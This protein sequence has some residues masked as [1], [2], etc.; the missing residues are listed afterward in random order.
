M[1]VP[2]PMKGDATTFVNIGGVD[3]LANLP[4]LTEAS[5]LAEINA[6]FMAHNI[7]TYV[8]DILI[9]M[10]P[11][12]RY[13]IYTKEIS[14]FY[15][16][17]RY[18]KDDLAPHA[19]Y[20]ADTAYQRITTTGKAQTFVISGESGAGK[21]ETTK[22][23]VGHIME[24]CKAGKTDLEEKIKQLNPFLEAFG[25]AKTVMNNNSSRFGKYLELKFDTMGNICGAA[26]LHY[27]L[28]KSRVTFRNEKEQS[29]HIFYQLYAGMKASNE[30]GNYGLSVPSAHVYLNN[31]PGPPDEAVLGN[32]LSTCGESGG[33]ADEWIECKE[34]MSFIKISDEL[35]TSMTKLLACSVLIGDVEFTEGGNDDAQVSGGN[36]EKICEL[37][38]VDVELMK[39]CLTTSSTVTRGEKITK[40]LTNEVAHGFKDAMAKGVF[41]KIFDWIFETSNKVLIDPKAPSDIV[42]IGVLDIFGFEVFKLNSI[43][44]MCIDLTNEQL[45]GYFNNH[46]FVAEQDEYKREGVDVSKIAFSDNQST[47]DLFLAKKGSIFAILDE[48]TRFPKASDATFTQKCSAALKDHPSK[49]FKPAR[50]DRDLMF[51]VEHYAGP[52]TYATI[53]FLEKNKDTLSQDIKDMLAGATDSLMKVI[54]DPNHPSNAVVKKAPTLA[55]IFKGSLGDLMHRMSLCEPQF[56]RCL[57]ATSKKKPLDWEEDLVTR[58]LKYAGVLETIKIRKLGYSVRFDFATFV[59][60]FKNIT[61]HYHE[62]V[63]EDQASCQALLTGLKNE[64]GGPL[65][66]DFQVGTTKVFLKYY[67]GDL[68]SSEARKHAQ[69]LLFLQNV[70]KGHVARE[71]YQEKLVE[72]RKTREECVRFLRQGEKAGLIYA[73]KMRVLAKKDEEIGTDRPGMGQLMEKAQDAEAEAM[74]EEEQREE[75]L[76]AVADEPKEE[77]TTPVNGYFTWQANEHLELKVGPLERPWREKVDEATGRTYFKNTETKT[78]SWVDPRSHTARPHDP[79]ECSGDELPFGWD[80]AETETGVVFYINHLLNEHHKDHPRDQLIAK[81][82]KLAKL[83]SANVEK[84]APILKVINELK[85]KRTLLTVQLGEAPDEQ[86][87]AQVEARIADITKTIDKNTAVLTKQR[88]GIDALKTQIERMK[89]TKSL[90]LIINQ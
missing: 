41:S 16:G 17:M 45:Q 36:L 8:G 21:T 2:D 15:Q 40:N 20:L 53:N 69:A 34:G 61:Y 47:L 65:I 71:L 1:P 42:T 24:L 50:S 87:R 84:E 81:Q 39:T 75:A 73:D 31:P 67:H 10:N 28:E 68:L 38:G 89:S 78:T 33:V 83:E 3:N 43:E 46:V 14:K 29:F 64:Q 56:V 86:A 70:V 44:Q 5:L 27:L 82:Q 88:N 7:M 32:T 76:A 18:A 37:Y 62:P 48:E 57:K 63:A 59:K 13:P 4:E 80:K 54:Y 26:M 55:S 12:Q 79:A 85:E 52:V 11:Y 66:D 25:N 60:K 74:E 9:V 49:A 6:R 35:I 19:Y 51:T 77:K 23:I 90:D 22:I 58:Q 30:L 72:A